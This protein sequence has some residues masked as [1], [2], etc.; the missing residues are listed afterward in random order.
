[1]GAR[2][3]G[4][5]ARVKGG[6]NLSTVIVGAGLMGRWHADAV[7]E[8]GSRIVA[9]V[10]PDAPRARRLAA[11]ADCPHLE[12][13]DA[14]LAKAPDVVHVCTPLETHE[15]LARAALT[16]RAAVLVEKPLAPDLA[17]TE[18]LLALAAS[19]G[20]LLAPVHQFLFQPGILEILDALPTLGRVRHLDLIA[21]SAGAEGRTDAEREAVVAEILPHP[22]ALLER[23][24]PGGVGAL[25][26]TVLRGGPGEVR[27]VA[28]AGEATVSVLISLAGRPTQNALHVVAEGGTAAADLFHG[29]AVIERGTASRAYKVARPFAVAGRQLGLA[30]ANLTARALRGEVAYPGLRTL[31][32]RFHAA[33]FMNEPNPVPAEQTIAVARARDV[34]LG[35]VRG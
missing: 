12:S 3:K 8:A 34:I 18:S 14:A 13:L 19:Q 31:V 32:A 1:M 21:C 28:R 29:F 27:A 15:G 2:V 33:V 20:R 6:A 30:A 5:D 9:I 4:M 35:G 10:D 11:D 22:L 16:A 7:R 24:L 25:A 26:W 23:L 17:T